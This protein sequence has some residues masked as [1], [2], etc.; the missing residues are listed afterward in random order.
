MGGAQPKK[1]IMKQPKQSVEEQGLKKKV[2]INVQHGK[3]NAKE[4]E[5][6]DSPRGGVFVQGASTEYKDTSSDYGVN[7]IPRSSQ[8]FK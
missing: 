4:L 2:K 7:V 3:S 5:V 6:F 8:A 1:S